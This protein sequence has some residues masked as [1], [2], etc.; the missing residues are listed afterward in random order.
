MGAAEF[1][2]GLKILEAQRCA[3]D[4]DAGLCWAGLL[5]TLCTL[6]PSSVHKLLTQH[7][8]TRHYSPR[9]EAFSKLYLQE[10][11]P[12]QAAHA[13]A[14]TVIDG[15][16]VSSTNELQAS[17][18]TQSQSEHRGA[19]TERLPIDHVLHTAESES[20]P[21]VILYGAPGTSSFHSA[22]SAIQQQSLDASGPDFHYIIRPVASGECLSRQDDAVSTWL[23]VGTGAP[24]QLAGYGVELFAKDTEYN[25]VRSQNQTLLK[26]YANWLFV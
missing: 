2:E 20:A 10:H 1:E 9:L 15:T 19:T 18:S 13:C 3:P 12:E 16:Y 17:L 8:A 24:L 4:S 7:L 25:Q 11:I 14:V 26:M 22:H 21:T 6:L 5:D 23:S